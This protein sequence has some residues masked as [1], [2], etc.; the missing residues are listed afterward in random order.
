MR[1]LCRISYEDDEHT[2][3]DILVGYLESFPAGYPLGYL[4]G[5]PVCYRQIPIGYPLQPRGSASYL[6]VPSPPPILC[7]E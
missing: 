5:Y 2:L 1:Y 7:S 4:S 6:Q 3:K